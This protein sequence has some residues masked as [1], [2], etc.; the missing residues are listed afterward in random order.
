MQLHD[1]SYHPYSDGV[2]LAVLSRPLRSL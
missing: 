2:A 1:V